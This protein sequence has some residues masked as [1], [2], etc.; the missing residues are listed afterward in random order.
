MHYGIIIYEC[1]YIYNLHCIYIY[2]TYILKMLGTMV[3]FLYGGK[4][5]ELKPEKT[6]CGQGRMVRSKMPPHRVRTG[7]GVPRV[8]SFL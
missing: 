4:L 6:V 2:K 3:Y 7:G 1:N 5:D 8:A